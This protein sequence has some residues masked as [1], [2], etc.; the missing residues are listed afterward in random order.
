[1]FSFYWNIRHHKKF[2]FKDQL[3]TAIVVSAADSMPFGV[4]QLY[5]LKAKEPCLPK[6]GH[7]IYWKQF[8]DQTKSAKSHPFKKNPNDLAIISHTGGT[9]GVPKGVMCSDK[10]INTVIWEIGCNLTNNRQ[11]KE[12]VVLPPFINYS[13]VDSMLAPLVLG[14]QVI[15]IPD[16]KPEKFAKHIKSY[17]PNHISSIPA[18]W[19]ALLTIPELK[20]M[21]LS[22]LNHIFYGGEGMSETT[23]AKVNELLL[24]SGAKH[25]LK[26]G[27]GSTEVI[28]TVTYDNCNLLNSVGIPFIKVNCKIINPD[29][30]DECTYNQ[31][32]EICFSGPQLGY[33][34]NQ[35][36]TDEVIKIHGDG[37]RW[38]HMGDLGYMNEDGVIFVSGRIKRIIM[39]KGK[40]GSVTKMF[41]DR[42][43]KV[44]M[45]YPA[46]QLCCVIGVPNEKRIN[47]AKAFVVT[48]DKD[49]DTGKI[50]VEIRKLCKEQLPEYMIPEDIEFLTDLPRTERGKVDYQS[51][52]KGILTE[53]K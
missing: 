39:T 36:A 8:F 32:G 35:A 41:P 49:A 48:N 30:G 14:H 25:K 26:K 31:V 29:N 9:T 22:C 34:N 53:M 28:A 42:I 1:M 23:E 40:D 46:T 7:I 33:Y 2:S 24:A 6:T 45:E 43:E 52:E 47:Y 3:K 20:T 13:L 10:N 21:D 27:L 50:S 15:L 12:L 51:L 38:I 17:H 11:E 44:I 37:G 18:Y 19:E 4:K 5:K 16:Y